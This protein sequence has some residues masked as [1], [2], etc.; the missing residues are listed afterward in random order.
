MAEVERH[1]L[2]LYVD[3]SDDVGKKTIP[4]GNVDRKI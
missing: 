1:Q 3:E 4:L 2:P